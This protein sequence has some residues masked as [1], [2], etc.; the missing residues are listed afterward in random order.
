MP[1][2]G[3][4]SAGFWPSTSRCHS[5]ICQRSGSDANAFAA[6]PPSKPAT[7]V[8]ANGTPGSYGVRSP[9]VVEPLLAAHL[10]DVQ[11]AYGGQQV[12]AE[13]HVRPTAAAAAR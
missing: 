9:V 4:M 7:A 1:S 2:S 6:A 10:V 5:T 12:G 13:R 3:A 11:A 8:S